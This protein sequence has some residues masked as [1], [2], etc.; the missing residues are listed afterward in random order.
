[1]FYRHFVA[2]KHDDPDV[3]EALIMR[4]GIFVPV[5][6]VRNGVG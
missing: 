1:M 2:A 3:R 4:F 5:G 6:E